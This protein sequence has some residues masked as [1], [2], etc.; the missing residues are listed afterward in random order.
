MYH[1]RSDVEANTCRTPGQPIPGQR[2]DFDSPGQ[3]SPSTLTEG[4]A[5]QE[6]T[7][8]EPEDG[9]GPV[10]RP[11]QSSRPAA[12]DGDDGE[13]QAPS[14]ISQPPLDAPVSWT[15]VYIGVHGGGTEGR[16][17]T[18]GTCRQQDGLDVATQYC[19]RDGDLEPVDLTERYDLGGGD[20]MGGVQ[21]GGNVQVGP[22][23]IGLEADI[24]R[25]TVDEDFPGEGA[26][27][28]FAYY[29]S[30]SQS[31]DWLGTVRAR[32]GLAFG[33]VMVFATGGVAV[34]DVS[35]GVV[36]EDLS[37]R[38]AFENEVSETK[39]GW[40]AG[41]GFE[42]GLGSISLKTEYLY[43]DLGD[44]RIKTEFGR[45]IGVTQRSEFENSGHV[46]RFGINFRLN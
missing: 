37:R 4:G 41:G 31:M 29:S 46:A 30:V 2:A 23:V 15:G 9:G 28:R 17:D 21:I 5:P 20:V 22:L 1:S 6:I 38:V 13:P 19:A 39:A 7:A 34:G 45:G 27:R 12:Q 11:A 16:R 32:A 8:Y 3:P 33:N 10:R 35:Y 44:D 25:T 24:S 26:S 42:L 40:T 36:L 43:Y 14:P 18:K